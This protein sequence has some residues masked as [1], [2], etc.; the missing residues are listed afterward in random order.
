MKIEKRKV[1]INISLTAIALQI[2][3]L[4]SLV[5]GSIKHH[6]KNLTN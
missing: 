6:V 4:D 2:T 3:F 5:W 1:I